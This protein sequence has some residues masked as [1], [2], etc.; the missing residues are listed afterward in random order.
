M[1]KPASVFHCNGV[2]Q[3]SLDER[4]VVGHRL[5]VSD[6]CMAFNHEC[7]QTWA[8][9]LPEKGP[10]RQACLQQYKYCMRCCTRAFD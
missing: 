6:G 10:S 5:L 9:Q 2:Q 8:S 1:L 7:V 4:P 3:W